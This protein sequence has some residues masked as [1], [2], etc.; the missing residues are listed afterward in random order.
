MPKVPYVRRGVCR[1]PFAHSA[2]NISGEGIAF[3]PCYCRSCFRLNR[4]VLKWVHSVPNIK[5][6]DT[7]IDHSAHVAQIAFDSYR[8]HFK[9]TEHPVT[10]CSGVLACQ[11]GQQTIGRDDR[12]KVAHNAFYT[13]SFVDFVDIAFDALLNIKPLGILQCGF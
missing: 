13:G 9:F 2:D 5:L 11:L 10:Y 3:F 1:Q 12:M 8:L 6:P 4:Q 7:E